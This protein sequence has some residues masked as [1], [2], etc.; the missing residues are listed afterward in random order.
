[1]ALAEAEAAGKSDPNLANYIE[2]VR[3]LTRR[4]RQ[5]GQTAAN[6]REYSDMLRSLGQR[7]QDARTQGS[8]VGLGA[9][10]DLL[11]AMSRKYKQEMNTSHRRTSPFFAAL[12]LP[13]PALEIVPEWVAVLVCGLVI[14]TIASFFAR[15]NL[16]GTPE[17]RVIWCEGQLILGA[18]LIFLSYFAAFL[19]VV[20]RGL[21]LSQWGLFFHPRDLWW[22]VWQRLPDTSFPIW[23]AGWGVG[24]ALGAVMVWV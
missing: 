7:L 8:N 23:L 11:Q 16:N 2:L 1:V 4:C 14:T 9:F 24:L 13:I 10:E 21:R 5:P 15:V 6:L 18:A 19:T 20:P 17:I 22:A 3:N 12:G